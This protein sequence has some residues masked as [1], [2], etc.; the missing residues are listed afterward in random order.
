[1]IIDNFYS[2]P[3]GEM[4]AGGSAQLIF[5]A[6]VLLFCTG[7]ILLHDVGGSCDG[8]FSLCVVELR[9]GVDHAPAVCDGSGADGNFSVCQSDRTQIICGGVDGTYWSAFVCDETHGTE[10]TVD[11]VD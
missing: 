1:M 9:G 8:D 6:A 11:H 2:L 7:R 4:Y 10:N 3:D 5:R